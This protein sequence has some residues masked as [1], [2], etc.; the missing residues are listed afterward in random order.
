[1]T[2]LEPVATQVADLINDVEYAQ[3]REAEGLPVGNEPPANLIFSGP[4]GT[5]KTTV[6]ELVAPLYNA[7]GITPKDKIVSVNPADL[8]GSVMG[9]TQEKVKAAFDKA[10]GGVLFIDE[11]YGLV[12]GKD[13]TYGKQALAVMASEMTKNPDTVVILAGY[14]KDI[15]DML[16]HNEGMPRRFQRT[17]NFK[18]Y[19]Q[20][21]RFDILMNTLDEGKYQLESPE[22]MDLLED[23]VLDTGGG[24]AGDVKNLFREIV[25]AQKARIVDEDPAEDRKAQLAT[26]T[27][28]DVKRGVRRFRDM[29]S[30]DK[31]LRGV[32]VPT[33][34]K[35]AS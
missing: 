17:I 1:M 28:A 5:G 15:K 14:E 8:Y 18:P 25:Q 35:K 23:A 20:G 11:A 12:T 2:G 3:E 30:V 26:I 19:D 16:A 27:E 29:G 33:S 4:S 32:L 9:E 22:V 10:K 13:D 7:L 31:P 34:R 21:D 6:A 24:N